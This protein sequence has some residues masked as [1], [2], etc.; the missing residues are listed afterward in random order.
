MRAWN[1]AFPRWRRDTIL[2]FIWKLLSP[3]ITR[4]PRS[5]PVSILAMVGLLD[6]RGKPVPARARGGETCPSPAACGC[7]DIFLLKVQHRTRPVEKI[8]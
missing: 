5:D 8:A 7:A 1:V 6:R 3:T 4:R 2:D